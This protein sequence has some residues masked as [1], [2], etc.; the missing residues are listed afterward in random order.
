MPESRLFVDD[1][2]RGRH[3]IARFGQEVLRRLEVPHS[4]LRGG[5]EPLSPLDVVN[6]H[7]LRLRT[8]DVVFSPGFNAG[9][10]RATQ[11]LTLHDLIHMSDPDEQDRRKTVYYERL[12]R[13]A[14]LRAGRVLTVS[15]TSRAAVREW[16]DDAVEVVDVGNGCSEVF[17]TTPPSPE[18]TGALYVGN[19][20]PH[21]NPGVAFAAVAGNAGLNFVVVTADVAEAQRL[22]VA[23]GIDDRTTVRSGVDDRELAGLY[24][25]AA[26]LLMPSLLEGFGLPAAEA[27]AMGCPVV[28]WS[29][30][31]AVAEIV[32]ADGLAVDDPEDGALWVAALERAVSGA[33]GSTRARIRARYSW[34]SVAGRVD[35]TIRESLGITPSTRS[36]P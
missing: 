13:P 17:F 24:G 33:G 32:E 2:W 23:H 27:L 5:S 31:R 4:A 3:G 11:L 34:D 1:R 36:R 21:K 25:G 8:T 7:R 20:K 26:A 12:V 28:H 30:C 22:A 18:R 35:A 29:G 15:E 16:L 6:P 10:S 9:L 14:V 19:L